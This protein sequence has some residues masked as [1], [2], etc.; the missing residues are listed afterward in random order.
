MGL[1][2][3]RLRM[4]NAF[5]RS[6]GPAWLDGV[7]LN[8]LALVLTTR[9]AWARSSGYIG[10]LAA[11]TLVGGLGW[12]LW[13]FGASRLRCSLALAGVEVTWTRA[14]GAVP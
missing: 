14:F 1:V 12:S 6:R 10:W 11:P 2:A 7:L 5:F 9:S 13:G 4:L 8:S 3:C